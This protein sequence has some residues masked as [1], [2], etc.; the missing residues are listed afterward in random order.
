[1]EAGLQVLAHG[2]HEPKPVIILFIL[3]V[4]FMLCLWMKQTFDGQ[5]P[6][7]KMDIF[8]VNFSSLLWY[9]K[10][11]VFVL[12]FF[13]KLAYYL[14][15]LAKNFL[16]HE[17]KCFYINTA[18][19]HSNLICVTFLYYMPSHCQ[20]SVSYVWRHQNCCHRWN[21]SSHLLTLKHLP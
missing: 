3:R 15:N 4:R 9:I 19:P 10:L 1:M 7:Q 6:L 18:W 8:S 21:G 12:I 11:F 20:M 14:K 17:I 13:F 2:S 5:A 16:S